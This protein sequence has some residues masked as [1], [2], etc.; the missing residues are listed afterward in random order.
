MNPAH[1]FLFLVLIAIIPF[2]AGAFL[3]AILSILDDEV[4]P[5]LEDDEED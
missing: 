2:F 1:L 3:L 4:L 5:Q